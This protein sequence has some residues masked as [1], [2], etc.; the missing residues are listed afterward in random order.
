MQYIVQEDGVQKLMDEEEYSSYVKCKE[1][2]KDAVEKAKAEHAKAKCEL[3]SSFFDIMQKEADKITNTLN[4]LNNMNVRNTVLDRP[5]MR[6]ITSLVKD[7]HRGLSDAELLKLTHQELSRHC[8]KK[9]SLQGAKHATCVYIFPMLYELCVER[10][11]RRVAAKCPFTV[12]VL[13]ELAQRD[14]YDDVNCPV[15][16]FSAIYVNK[17]NVVY[18]V[19]YSLKREGWFSI[20]EEIDVRVFDD[21]KD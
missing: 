15:A 20:K 19:H 12:K 4:E 21:R 8:P 1:K 17:D 9:V 16:Y 14:T 6:M 11:L 13:H 5:S 2:M 7:E 18:T 10:G 3:E